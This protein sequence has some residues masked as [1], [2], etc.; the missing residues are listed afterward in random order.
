MQAAA[1]LA[2]YGEHPEP[3]Q[4]LPALCRRLQADPDAVLRDARLLELLT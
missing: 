1:Y 2:S 3:D 4:V